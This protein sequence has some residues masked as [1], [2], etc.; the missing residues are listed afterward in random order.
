MPFILIFLLAMM[1]APAWAQDRQADA[2]QTQD[3]AARPTFQ[4]IDGSRPFPLEII[5][6]LIFDK[7]GFL[8]IGTREGLLLNDGQRFRRFQHE[9]QN[10]DSISSNGIRGIFEDSR[11]RLWINT[12]SGGLNQLDRATWKFRSWRHQ[13]N[14]P[15]SLIHDGVFTLA[16][17][18]DGRLWVGTQAGL[19]LFD[20]DSGHFAR[21]VL[22]TGGEFVI[23]LHLDRHDRLWAATL[24]QGLFRER[25]DHSGF[26]SI[27]F[28]DPPAQ[29]DVFSIA[30]DAAGDIWAGARFGLYRVDQATQ[31]LVDA[32]PNPHASER[33]N[34]IT[35][36]LPDTDGS[37]WLGTFGMGLFHKPANSQTVQEIALAAQA[38]GAKNIDSG[39]LAFAPDGTLFVGTFGAGL[40][41][42]SPQLAGL[43][44]WSERSEAHPG[45]A[46]ADVYILRNASGF[47]D[48]DNLLVG[49]FGGGIDL[50][51]PA[52]GTI[53]HMTL[54][55]DD[56]F[57]LRLGGITDLLVAQGGVLWA[58][59][60]EGVYRWDRARAE[61]HY[62]APEQANA[63]NPIPE[64][65]FALL[66]DQQ[67]RIWVGSAG[68]GLFL[69]HDEDNSFRNFM[70]TRGEQGSLP[71]DFVTV[72][73]EDR[74]NRLWV[75]TRS[76]GIGVCT[77][78]NHLQCQSIATGLGKTQ[79]S[80]DH[81]T[82]LLEAGDGS[83]WAG[84]HGG[85]LNQLHLDA[86]GAVQ[87]VDHWTRNNGLVD[88]NVMAMVHAPDGAL[89]FSTH[90]GLSRLDA[91]TGALTNLTPADGLPTAIFNPKAAIRIGDRLYFGSAKGV[92]AIDP[93]GPL[94]HRPAPA[95]V[96]TAISGLDASQSPTRPAWQLDSLRVS[97]RSPLA[98]DL[99]VLGYGGGQ[100]RFQ[101]RLNSTD[102]WTD[103]GD[104]GQLT[105]HALEP[106]NYRLEVR[107]RLGGKDW[108]LAKPLVLEVVPPWWR[109]NSVQLGAALLLLASLIGVFW[110]RMRELE[111]R[112]SE[113]KHL[114]GLREQ[115]LAE[116]KASSQRLGDA[117][118]L[119][120]RMTMRLEAAKERERTH[121]A[122]ELHDE[123][124]QAL[125][126][127]KINLGLALQQSPSESS[128]ARTRDAIAV[129]DQLIAQVRALSLDLRP[130]LLDE[131][132][133]LPALEGHLRGVAARGG[134]Q[135]K[136]T[137]DPALAGA[138]GANDIT[139]FRI[140][141]EAVTN[142]VRHAQAKNLEVEIAAEAD[143]IAV[144][145]RDDGRG[146]D[147]AATLASSGSGL[148]L[149]GMRER[150]HDLGGQWS[151]ESRP[152]C[153]TLV[154]AFIPA[155]E[156]VEA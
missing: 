38:S 12:I 80:H 111:S 18:R 134:L 127:A 30:E 97:W 132:G 81:I 20:P 83:I 51:D 131:M 108:T 112:H 70:P 120:R 114:H 95:T 23:A 6:E 138:A 124:G 113:L 58:T 69:Y 96:I 109:R 32:T 34:N 118:A 150:V 65:S 101:Y 87:S 86:N 50:I 24:G 116:A 78:A 29:L 129:I 8:W 9:A 105:L 42:A 82:S 107:G 45:L 84:T 91:K 89:W 141:Q 126:T 10:P 71:N 104:H 14:D 119:L 36:L 47:A 103:L 31:R 90:G 40:L 2:K 73:L 48:A 145:V 136:L 26:D 99:A 110:W 1:S 35:A 155:S 133:L 57:N 142:V 153:G 3:A 74:R 62:F 19:D 59:T 148:G 5:T 106:G 43:Q 66:E 137:F 139:I 72:L 117:F 25:D 115:A 123:F 21:T 33:I 85:G 93:R 98:F 15:E 154:T 156:S 11:G 4:S 151:V 44:V 67:N 88:D 76:G 64:Y 39:A 16:E 140:V 52:Q 53:E 60:N 7:A 149:F 94:P 79:V 37:L 54:P 102:E 100:P 122:R 135:L 63:G 28:A 55:G 92:V 143:G 22:A 144:R 128:L 147:A 125:T 49:S 75:G 68:G 13:H 130:P 152:G 61:F 121:L 146:F 41:R 56:A 27:P 17:A 46:N 77:Y